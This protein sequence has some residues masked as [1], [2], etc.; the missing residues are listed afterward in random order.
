M[1]VA[2][3][4]VLREILPLP[5]AGLVSDQPAS[6]VAEQFR[7]LRQ[8]ADSIADW[9][10]PTRTFKAVVG[11]S[12]ACNPGPHLTDRGL[13]DGTTGEIFAHAQLAEVTGVDPVTA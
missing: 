6:E 3:G 2:S 4:G 11:A 1:A 7:R 5:F 10:P 13:T 12:L 8:A 9:K